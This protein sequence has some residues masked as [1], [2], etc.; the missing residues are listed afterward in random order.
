MVAASFP[1]LTP[2]LRQ[3]GKKAGFEID[4]AVRVGR[5]CFIVSS[6]GGQKQ[7]PR[8]PEA[9]RWAIRGSESKEVLWYLSEIEEFTLLYTEILV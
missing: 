9:K 6:K 5:K 2:Y 4:L 8:T 1:Q 3:L 7:V